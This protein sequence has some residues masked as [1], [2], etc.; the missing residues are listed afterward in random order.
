MRLKHEVNDNSFIVNTETDGGQASE[1]DQRR[2]DAGAAETSRTA[3]V[4]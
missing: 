1:A 4:R 3:G 2:H